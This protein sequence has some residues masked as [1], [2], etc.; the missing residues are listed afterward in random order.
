MAKPADPA[1]YARIRAELYKEMPTHSA[2][3]SGQLVQR[4][5]R[6]GGTYVGPKPKKSGPDASGLARWFAEEWRTQSGAEEYQKPGDVFRPTKRI[7]KDT[8][9]TFG[10]LTA[11]EIKRAQREKKTTGRVKEFGAKSP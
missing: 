6:A 2:Y 3:R 9:T 4:Y 10:E 1:L 5:K 7:S 8:P 11:A